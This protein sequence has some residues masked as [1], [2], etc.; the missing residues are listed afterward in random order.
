MKQIVELMIAWQKNRYPGY[1]QNIEALSIEDI[2]SV[3]NDYY[4]G[5]VE[6]FI[7][8]SGLNTEGE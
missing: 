8:D 3:V 5:G 1:E 7:I 2:F 6:Q 4:D